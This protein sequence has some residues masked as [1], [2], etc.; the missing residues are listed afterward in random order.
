MSIENPILSTTLTENFGLSACHS[1]FSL[2]FGCNTEFM[3]DT[4]VTSTRAKEPKEVWCIRRKCVA[5]FTSHHQHGDS[6]STLQRNPTDPPLLKLQS[7]RHSVGSLKT[8]F[9]Q[10]N[11]LSF[12]PPCEA[13]ET[14]LDRFDHG[15]DLER[16]YEIIVKTGFT[17]FDNLENGGIS[18]DSD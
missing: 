15:G 12:T 3:R 10:V 2:L 17:R 16:F 14:I 8:V 9:L 5:G 1:G 11:L 18:R 13:F 4:R 6:D 7:T